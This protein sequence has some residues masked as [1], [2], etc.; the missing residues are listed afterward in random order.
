MGLLETLVALIA[1][2]AAALLVGRSQGRKAERAKAE[3]AYRETRE[4]MD[5]VVV[6][7]DPAVA[8]GW[9]RERGQ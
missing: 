9:L 6:G 2:V 3:A 1:A 8:R 7:D 5:E 4:K